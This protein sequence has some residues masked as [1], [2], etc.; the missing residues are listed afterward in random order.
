MS[1]S[2]T[3]CGVLIA[4]PLVW[5]ETITKTGKAHN[6]GKT[7]G[8]EVRQRPLHMASLS[9]AF[10]HKTVTQQ[11]VGGL[12]CA[13]CNLPV[14]SIRAFI[15]WKVQNGWVERLNGPVQIFGWDPSQGRPSLAQQDTPWTLSSPSPCCPPLLWAWGWKICLRM[16]ARKAFQGHNHLPLN[17]CLRKI[18][19]NKINKQMRLGKGGLFV[20]QTPWNERDFLRLPLEDWA[21]SGTQRA[22]PLKP[23]KVE[24]SASL[25]PK[26]ICRLWTP[27]PANPCPDLTGDRWRGGDR[28]RNMPPADNAG[29]HA[30]CHSPCQCLLVMSDHR[31]LLELL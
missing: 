2:S 12:L 21:P 7:P 14:Q 26:Q 20:C 24:T 19:A 25:A 18:T 29:L 3:F 13:W 4:M 11:S 6:V 17:S 8:Q 22:R 15:S 30:Q 28:D 5:R 9:P 16:R 23:C 10:A 27:D 1:N 31:H